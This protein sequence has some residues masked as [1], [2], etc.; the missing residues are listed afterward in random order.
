MEVI[1]SNPI[2][3][4]IEP[5]RGYESDPDSLTRRYLPGREPS[6]RV[7]QSCQPDPQ[8]SHARGFIGSGFGSARSRILAELKSVGPTGQLLKTSSSMPESSGP[9]LPLKAFVACFVLLGAAAVLFAQE[10]G[11]SAGGKWMEFDSQD[12]MTLVKKTRFE[13]DADNSLPG[14]SPTPRSCSSAPLANWT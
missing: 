11:I 6:P 13:L 1:G 3:P 2:A 7:V 12:Q 5:Q 4:T 8:L 9:K 10:A 14:S